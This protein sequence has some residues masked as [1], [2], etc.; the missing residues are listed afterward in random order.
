MTSSNA[1]SIC[2]VAHSAYGA[3]TGGRHCHIGG[4]QRQQAMMAKWLAK[5]GWRVSMITWD[6]GQPQ[7][8]VVDGVR[9][10]KMCRADACVKGV[11]F[12][13]P[14]WTSLV[15]ALR[16]ADA[17]VYYQNTAEYVTGQVALWCRRH[18]KKFVYSVANDPDCDPRLPR[19]HTLRERILYRYGL[20]RAD[21]VVAQT[22]K[23]QGMLREGFGLE[24]VVLPM[25]CPGPA[26][27]GYAAPAPPIPPNRPRIL[28][29]G[30]ICE[31]KRPDRLTEL[32]AALP[33]WRFD[34]VGPG[35]G[36]TYSQD[37]CRRA[38]GLPNVTVHGPVPR[39]RMPGLYQQAACLLCTS[40]FEGFP[41]TFL[42]AWSQGLPMVTTFDPDDLI[43][44]RELGLVAGD[45][46]GLAAAVRRLL[47]S[48]DLY[49]RLS[50]NARQYYLENHT[51]EVA[52][53]RFERLFSDVVSNS[54][55]HVAL[56]T[57]V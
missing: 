51:V 36:D 1:P 29:V 54:G 6:E 28:W 18:G 30:R 38:T 8:K 50:Q 14:K 3:L 53:P 46:P 39:D 27:A 20:R 13:H 42:E 19:M 23:Q 32:A 48:P 55:T 37:V 34:F 9:V 45:V 44:R 2:F 26:D 57:R 11:R 16:A 7:S 24:S 17:D 15:H 56:R 31:Q 52:M 10:I 25:P 40:D 47:T 41:N 5:R 21:S 43:A 49:R 33:E 35:G 12:F 22:Q 4:I